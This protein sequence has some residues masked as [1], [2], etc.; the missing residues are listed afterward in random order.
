MIC[1]G[2]SIT[3]NDQLVAFNR[4]PNLA[5]SSGDILFSPDVLEPPR[6]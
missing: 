6:S 5:R 3:T 1:P 2:I 4:Y